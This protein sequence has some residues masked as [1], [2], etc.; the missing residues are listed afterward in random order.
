MPATKE[1][2]EMAK[3][4]YF[5]GLLMLLQNLLKRPTFSLSMMLPDDVERLF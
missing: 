5:T 4:E 2:E 1:A 3:K